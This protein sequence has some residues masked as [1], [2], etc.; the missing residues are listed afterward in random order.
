MVK[1]TTEIGGIIDIEMK[2]MHRALIKISTLSALYTSAALTAALTQRWFQ[3]LFGL[4]G[5]YN[6]YV[7]WEDYLTLPNF[8]RHKVSLFKFTPLEL[9]GARVSDQPVIGELGLLYDGC[10]VSKETHNVTNSGSSVLLSFKKPQVMNGFYFRTLASTPEQDPVR[11]TMEGSNDGKSWR[12]VGG[13]GT[14]QVLIRG[15][16]IVGSWSPTTLERLAEQTF[17]QRAT[18]QNELYSLSAT[19]IYSI[20]FLNVAGLAARGSP[21]RGKMA[22]VTTL[23]CEAVHTFTCAIIFVAS[24]RTLESVDAWLR[25][26]IY[27]TVSF[28]LA[29]REQHIIK[30]MFIFGLS[31]VLLPWIQAWTYNG[32]PL[33]GV[34]KLPPIGIAITSIILIIMVCRQYLL[35]RAEKTIRCDMD[36]YNNV[37]EQTL[38]K[39][40]T[41]QAVTDLS[42]L[43]NQLR[44]NVRR[45]FLQQCNKL[46][47]SV[48]NSAAVAVD[49]S[50]VAS[51][52][53]RLHNARLSSRALTKAILNYSS[54]VSSLDQVCVWSTCVSIGRDNITYSC[55]YVH[56]YICNA[57]VHVV[58]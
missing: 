13:S 6:V 49:I 31:L 34:T 18:W 56:D 51:P 20:G 53:G 42:N 11:F 41:Q 3:I 48:L 14:M 46:N 35:Y 52:T 29:R 39:E 9:R 32:H 57:S 47:V 16:P 1:T 36:T 45:P 17:D 5:A 23:S 21:E 7:F 22:V 55:I 10:K 38:R 25:F 44:L 58:R 8:G 27:I 19:L 15:L 37:W 54:P 30:D 50:S 40:G 33:S 4:F 28:S 24:G 2:K 26:F 43:C 12:A